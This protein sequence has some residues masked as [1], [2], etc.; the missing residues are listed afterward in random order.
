MRVTAVVRAYNEAAHLGRLLQGL[1]SQTTPVEEIVVVDSGS[2]D[3]TVKIATEGGCRVVHI[4][5]EEFTFGRSLNY[6]CNAAKG[7]L[8]LILSAHVYPLYDTFVDHML[9]PFSDPATALAYGRQVG[10]GRTKYA[11]A[12]IMQQWFPTE[13]IR[14]QPHPFSNNAN[15][16]IRKDVWAQM[17]YDERLT[18]LEDLDMAKRALALGMRLDYVAEAPVVHVHEETWSTIRNRYRREA[19]AYK[20]I[21]DEEQFSAW[22]AVALAG[23]NIASDYWHAMRDRQLKTNLVEIPK[24]RAAQFLGA[25]E[26]FRTDPGMSQGLRRRFY[27]PDLARLSP[28]DAIGNRIDYDD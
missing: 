12:R 10:D 20:A 2:A 6:G 27:Y 18:G 1:R 4:S 5:K 15:A 13:S 28:N 19:I 24:F 8:L 17:R 11:E 21:M 16:I 23:I 3:D 9:K 14:N 25:A 26:G 7:E 22:E